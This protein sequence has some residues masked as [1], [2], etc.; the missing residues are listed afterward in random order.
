MKSPIGDNVLGKTKESLGE[1]YK[2]AHPVDDVEGTMAHETLQLFP[3]HPTG[4]LEARSQ[5][6]SPSTSTQACNVEEGTGEQAFF[7]FLSNHETL[8]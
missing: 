2:S 3:L 7:N 4:I 6:S 8:Q 1:G 5:I